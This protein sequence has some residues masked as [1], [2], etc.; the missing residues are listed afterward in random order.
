M[1]PGGGWPV[2][3]NEG[4][5]QMLRRAVSRGMLNHAYLFVGPKGS[6]K[7]LLARTF[8]Q[9]VNCEVSGDELASGAP[10]GLCSQCSRIRSGAHP[11]VAFFDLETQAAA[12]GAGGKKVAPQKE[13]RIET[14]RQLQ[15]GLALRPY[16][17]RRKI[18]IIGDAD[19]MNEEA[20]NCLLK[21]LEEPPSHSIL[22]LLASDESSVLPTTYSRCTYVPLR[23]VARE[24]ITIY[25]QSDRGVEEE[26]ARLL[27]SL[28]G[29]RVGSAITLLESPETLAARSRALQELATLKG[30]TVVDRLDASARLAKMFTDARSELYDLL[31]TWEL[32]FRDLLVTSAGAADLLMNVDQ[33]PALASQAGKL[34]AEAALQAVQLVSVTRRQLAENVNP[35]LALEALTLG[36]P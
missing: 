32:W 29:G 27:S 10:C 7:R 28:A 24:E 11:D 31:D 5:V 17:A 21:S 1:Q 25:L 20:A 23:T 22:V 36:L 3:G 33:R 16:S 19:R 35:R 6:G 34:D 14:V 18:Y 13:L 26:R 2:V 30:A 9:A 8:A 12:A 15:D 4:A